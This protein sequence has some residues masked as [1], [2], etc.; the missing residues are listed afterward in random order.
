[1]PSGMLNEIKPVARTFE[2]NRV[3]NCRVGGC[4]A[5]EVPSGNMPCGRMPVGTAGWKPL[6]GP[7]PPDLRHGLGVTDKFDKLSH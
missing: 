3:G 5:G 2:E 6:E 7:L 1:M 4:R